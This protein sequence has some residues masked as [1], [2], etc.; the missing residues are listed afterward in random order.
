MR[1]IVVGAGV[2]GL[3]SAVRLAE[4]GHD[5]AVLARDL[6][7]ETTSAVAAAWWYPHLALPQDRVTAWAATSYDVFAKLVAEG[8]GEHGETGVLMRESIELL[9]EP[10]ADPWWASAVPRLTRALDLPLGYADG[11]IFDAPVVEMPVYLT[12]LRRR[13]E[14][15]GATLTR[16][17]LPTLPTG[18]DLVVNA[19]GLSNRALVGDHSL[20]PVRGQVVWVRQ[21]GLDRVWLDSTTPASTY[22][23][24]RSRDI[25]I[26]GTSDD[27]SW[28]LRPDPQVARQIL[29]RAAALVP[30]LADAPVLAHRVGLRPARPRVRV[31]AERRRN[32]SPVVHCYGHG[33][34]GVT[35]SWGCAAEV[36]SLVD[37][38]A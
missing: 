30:E 2:I 24:P 20:H 37:A 1:V 38:L 25:V 9:G 17:A 13:A 4:G 8:G 6:P 3:T 19:A 15:A 29:D 18:A 36:A 12:Y 28:D 33:G 16:I 27:G 32:A 10:T 21:V 14:A 7:L 23:V 31:E 26:G 35:L 5:V 34:A 22:L 11:W